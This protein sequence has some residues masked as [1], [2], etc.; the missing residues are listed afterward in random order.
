MSGADSAENF[1]SGVYDLA[2][3]HDLGNAY[4]RYRMLFP[5]RKL[6]HTNYRLSRFAVCSSRSRTIP[7]QEQELASTRE[8]EALNHQLD[9]ARS[10][11]AS[12][13]RVNKAAAWRGDLY[14]VF[15]NRRV[16]ALM[17]YVRKT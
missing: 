3:E 1:D 6:R 14:A 16:W 8:I 7:A 13:R 10:R 2:L 5:K 4:G 11:E 9:E 15:G 12:I 17:E